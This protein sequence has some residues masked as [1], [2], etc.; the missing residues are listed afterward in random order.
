MAGSA[1][2]DR[3]AAVLDLNQRPVQKLLW[4]CP[5]VSGASGLTRSPVS[6]L[7]GGSRE[8]ELPA[9]RRPEYW[10]DE[11]K[12]SAAPGQN[13]LP[14]HPP[15]P[16]SLRWARSTALRRPRPRL[17]SLHEVLSRGR[18]HRRLLRTHEL[19]QNLR[20]PRLTQVLPPAISRIPFV[21][22]V[23]MKFEFKIS[24]PIGYLDDT[25][26]STVKKIGSTHLANRRPARSGADRMTS[27]RAGSGDVAVSS[28]LET[29]A[30][31]LS[32]P[33][34]RKPEGGYSR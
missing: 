27:A 24:S 25:F 14:S 7:C 22:F 33:R 32:C 3:R 13:T 18:E 4:I 12:S 2:L 21:R 1:V 5:E 34:D 29:N 23:S 11:D 15:P 9:L 17:D 30:C 31:G 6:G 10:V 20:R 19:C 8:I 16:V 28:S 26:R